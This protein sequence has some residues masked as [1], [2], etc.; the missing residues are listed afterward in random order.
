LEYTF[1]LIGFIRKFDQ[2]EKKLVFIF[3]I[4]PTFLENQGPSVNYILFAIFNIL[5]GKFLKA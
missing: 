1:F 2:V 5:L 3:L 4:Y